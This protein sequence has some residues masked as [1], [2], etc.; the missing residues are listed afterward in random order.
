MFAPTGIGVLYGKKEILNAMPP[1]Q[2]GG[3][4]IK[5][6]SFEG[7][8]YADLPYKFEAGT[9]NIAG[10][11]G[12]GVAV[13]YL[14]SS[15][16]KVLQK[17]EELLLHYAESELSKIKGI[18][19]YG[20]AENKVPVISFLIEDLHPYDVGTLLDKM[21]IAVR[22]GHHC[23]QPLMNRFCIPGTI[24]VSFAFYNTLEEIDL[25]IIALKRAI[26]ILK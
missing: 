7:S 8:T 24:R 19:F 11:I 3:E 13:D 25:F 23:T 20:V 17:Q 22:T 5:E 9:P 16:K 6:V 15:N 2:G 21:G 10:A 1:Y 12:L 14:H 18:Q 26:E 4:M